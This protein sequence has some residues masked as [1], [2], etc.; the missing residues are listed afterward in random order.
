MVRPIAGE[1]PSVEKYAPS[2]ASAARSSVVEN[3][4][5]AGEKDADA[6]T[7]L[8]EVWAARRSWKSGHDIEPVSSRPSY[9][10]TTK[11]TRSGS[12]A[13]ASLRKIESTTEYTAAVTATPIASESTAKIVKRG[14]AS[15]RRAASLRSV[16]L[17]CDQYGT[18]LNRQRDSRRGG[19]LLQR[20]IEH[21]H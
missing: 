3:E 7:L 15:S 17:R 12:R 4:V 2:T 11:T 20:R 8:K 18:I 1:T 5:T 21:G 19:G 10:E 14:V 6:D 16:M 13:P 9:G